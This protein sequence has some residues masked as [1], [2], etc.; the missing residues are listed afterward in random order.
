MFNN[1]TNVGASLV[2]D[3]VGESMKTINIREELNK[4]DMES[5][6]TDFVNMYECANLSL[7]KKK[8][9]VKLLMENKSNRV[10]SKFF[11]SM[12]MQYIVEIQPETEQ[13]IFN[14]YADALD[15]Y[16]ARVNDYR[17]ESRNDDVSVAL[18]KVID[19]E[20]I[21]T[22]EYW[23]K[24]GN[25][26]E[27]YGYYKN[28]PY[29]EEIADGLENGM[30]V[31]ETYNGTPWELT[32]HGYSSDEFNPSFADYL[33]EEVAYPVRDGHLAYLG[34]EMILYKS[35][36]ES[37]FGYG[38]LDKLIPDLIKLD[39]DRETIDEWLASPDP[40]AVLDFHYDFDIAF[41]VDEWESNDWDLSENLEMDLLKKR[42]KI[43]KKKNRA[44]SDY[45]KHYEAPYKTKRFDKILK[46]DSELDSIENELRD[47]VGYSDKDFDLLNNHNSF[48]PEDIDI[49]KYTNTNTNSK[50][51]K[52]ATFMVDDGERFKGYEEG[53]IWNGWY[54]PWFTKEEGLKIAE[55][56][57]SYTEDSLTFDETKDAFKY[58]LQDDSDD[59][60]YYVGANIN[61]EDGVKHLYPIGNKSWTWDKDAEYEVDVEPDASYFWY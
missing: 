59:I 50:P 58:V 15:Y 28:E 43:L 10:I 27:Q 4:R 34:I 13:E 46:A 17:K 12:E 35:S 23:K 36:M 24:D 1:A 61:T 51:L 54:C 42:A 6:T 48:L 37:I 45:D 9:L 39:I 19:D 7:D 47:K 31:G 49:T 8:S 29:C 53:Y 16:N 33:A 21:D 5:C 32:I 44:I 14:N 3:A 11:E 55:W 25:L 2:S 26:K 22:I 52:Q 56:I 57:N 20:I 40:D 38:E 60:D 41:D 30:W 18:H